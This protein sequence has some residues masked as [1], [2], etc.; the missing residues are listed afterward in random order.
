MLIQ[1]KR[2]NPGWE[3]DNSPGVDREELCASV[4]PRV[5]RDR[6]QRLARRL[7]STDR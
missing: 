1:L 5:S 3:S 6:G 4:V 2:S 7:I